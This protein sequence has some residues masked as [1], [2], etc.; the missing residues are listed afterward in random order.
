MFPGAEGGRS[1]VRLQYAQ[2]NDNL[3]ICVSSVYNLRIQHSPSLAVSAND[4]RQNHD[5]EQ[6][7]GNRQ[8]EDED[9]QDAEVPG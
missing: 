1:Q 9:E 3:F 2:Q 4:A 6:D 7:K 5:D 8:D